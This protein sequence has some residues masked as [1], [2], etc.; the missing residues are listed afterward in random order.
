MDK[1]LGIKTAPSNLAVLGSPP[2][3]F[4][5]PPTLHWD[6]ASQHLSASTYSAVGSALAKFLSDYLEHY[7]PSTLLNPCQEP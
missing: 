7:H 2:L 1:I 5:L 3:S 4:L 6:S